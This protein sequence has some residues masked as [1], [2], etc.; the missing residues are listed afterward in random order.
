MSGK[1]KGKPHIGPWQL[2]RILG[3]GVSSQVRLATHAITGETAT[4]KIVSKKSAAMKQSGQIATLDQTAW[5]SSST[6]ARQVSCGIE[7]EAVI[8][9]V[10][11]HP[12]II[13]LYDV[14]ETHDELR[15]SMEEAV[16]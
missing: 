14:W 9:K 13:S 4:I 8:M 2:G 6:E 5:G 7:R 10:I 12:N 15:V 11:A 1:E 16:F 3:E